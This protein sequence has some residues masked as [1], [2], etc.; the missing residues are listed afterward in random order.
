MARPLR[1]EY[2]NA[3]YHVMNRGTNR[4]A[5]YNNDHHRDIF[6]HSLGECVLKYAIEIHAYCLMNNHYHLLV[7]TPYANLSRAM[8]HIDGVYTQRYNRL[9]NRDGSLFRGRYKAVLIDAE[10]YLVAVSRYIHRNPV[11]ARICSNPKQYMWSSY[12]AYIGDAKKPPWL[13]IDELLSYTQTQNGN[14]YHELIEN[15]LLP[16]LKEYEVRDGKFPPILGTKEFC[17]S[18]MTRV[19]NLAGH[20]EIP[21]ASK[22][23]GRVPLSMIVK[24]TACAFGK[25]PEDLLRRKRMK[26]DF[27]RAT[28]MYLA[29]RK[30]GHR[31]NDIAK[32]F[33]LTDTGVSTAVIVFE[34]RFKEVASLQKILEEITE[35]LGR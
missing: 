2:E 34:N 16:S 21:E 18:A 4:C 32:E 13:C 28:A 5:I 20:P 17:E 9:E 3:W 30:Y 26:N 27:A 10:N 8:R 19:K 7:K 14:F 31:L 24:T 35:K 6:S 11:E 23:F 29:N 12:L 1:I 25:N 33:R 15:S 22:R